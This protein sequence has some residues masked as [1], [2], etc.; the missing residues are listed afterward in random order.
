MTVAPLL[1]WLMY[2]PRCAFRV[3]LQSIESRIADHIDTCCP[4]CRGRGLDAV[5]Y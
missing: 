3:L 5:E 2:C 1:T 4:L